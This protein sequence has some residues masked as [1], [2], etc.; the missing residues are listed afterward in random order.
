M[1]WGAACGMV[2]S[3]VG[4]EDAL[5]YFQS[6]QGAVADKLRETPTTERAAEIARQYRRAQSKI[7]ERPPTLRRDF[8]YGMN[9]IEAAIGSFDGW[10]ARTRG[11]DQAALTALVTVAQKAHRL[12]IT[13]SERSLALDSGL[14]R[15]TLK[16][17][18]ER[19]VSYGF[20]E[21]F[22]LE[23]TY[24]SSGFVLSRPAPVD[25]L[26]LLSSIGERRTY[27]T[28]SDPSHDAFAPKAHGK[29]GWLLLSL[30]PPEGL[31]AHQLAQRCGYQAD[32]PVVARLR[33][34]QR[35]GN[36]VECDEA[37]VWTPVEGIDL[38]EVAA[39][40]GTAGRLD[41]MRARFDADRA[42]R[43]RPHRLAA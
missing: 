27:W 8:D 36:L 35:R 5:M 24:G 33:D 43:L 38:D 4:L 12:D 40:C 34:M 10:R 1:V 17:A 14:D 7:A 32:R 21:K 18:L 28:H 37:G 19:L 25:P 3:Q 16:R 2:N 22:A 6:A 13:R 9:E 29:Q 23:T 39:L 30:L 41:R 31:T 15:G 26:S 42:R 20:I 11:E